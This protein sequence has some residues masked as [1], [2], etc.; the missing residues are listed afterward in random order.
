ME[1]FRI[2]ASAES[3]EECV[4]TIADGPEEALE[5]VKG[6]AWVCQQLTETA[7]AEKVDITEK[8]ANR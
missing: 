7:Y 1:V 6:N 3:E 2:Y 5:L 4:L 8:G